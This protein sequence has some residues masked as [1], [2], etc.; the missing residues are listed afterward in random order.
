MVVSTF[1]MLDKDDRERLFEESCLLAN[2]KS[3]TMLEI[4]FLI[5]NK[6]EVYF[7]ARTYNRNP[8]LP[9]TSF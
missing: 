1:S 4:L 5:I 2:V 6:A 7:Q 8:I 9:E 3:E